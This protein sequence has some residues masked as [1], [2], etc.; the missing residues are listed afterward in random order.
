LA[1]ALCTNDAHASRG[2]CGDGLSSL[3]EFCDCSLE[4]VDKLLISSLIEYQISRSPML[5]KGKAV[6][7]IGIVFVEL[8]SVALQMLRYWSGS[9]QLESRGISTL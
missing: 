7:K 5:F 9:R 4:D 2:V 3:E 6:L 1:I 8:G